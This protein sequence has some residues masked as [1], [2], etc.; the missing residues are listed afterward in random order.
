[1]SLAIFPI[2]T[3]V[4][5]TIIDQSVGLSIARAVGCPTPEQDT[6]LPAMYQGTLIETRHSVF[7]AALVRDVQAGTRD[8]GSAF[9]PTGRPDDRGPSTAVRMEHYTRLAPPLAIEASARA[10]ANSGLRPRELTHLVTVS[11]TGFF[12][13]GIDR[14]LLESLGLRP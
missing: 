7:P 1:M 10:L 9:L 6:W 4:P 11:C 14:L 12:A 5:P 13:P 2:G 8:S 3:A